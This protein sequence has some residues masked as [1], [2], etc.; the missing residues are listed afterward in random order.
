MSKDADNLLVFDL[1]EVAIYGVGGL[2]LW[3]VQFAKFIG[4]EFVAIARGSDTAHRPG[5]GAIAIRVGV[6]GVRSAIAAR[7]PELH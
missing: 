4:S 7:F 3:R 5:R 2:G 1:N 6:A